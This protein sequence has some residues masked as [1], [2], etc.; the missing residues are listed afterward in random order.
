[1]A[2]PMPDEPPV[3]TAMRSSSPKESMPATPTRADLGCR[4]GLRLRRRLF[5]RVELRLRLHRLRLELLDLDLGLG[6][7]L[8]D[9]AGDLRLRLVS[10]QCRRRGAGLRGSRVDGFLRRG[11]RIDA[12]LAALRAPSPKPAE[13]AA[14]LK[15]LI[16]RL[17]EVSRV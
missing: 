4:G 14:S 16:A 6:D 9:Q 8:R 15:A 1:M 17:D 5:D 2:S 3:T 13:C 10:R 12:A 7:V 11:P